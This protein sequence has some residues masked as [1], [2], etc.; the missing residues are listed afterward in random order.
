MLK[1][2]RLPPLL[3]RRPTSAGLCA[4]LR[5]DTAPNTRGPYSHGDAREVDVDVPG[6]CPREHSG[7]R[8]KDMGGHGRQRAGSR[9]AS[10]GREEQGGA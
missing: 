4:L 3:G 7:L 8:Q 1:M 9:P 2:P 10:H 6:G 5:S